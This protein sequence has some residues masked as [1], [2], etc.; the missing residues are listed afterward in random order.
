VIG[1]G[2]F[3][4][5]FGI[6]EQRMVV[7]SPARTFL[8]IGVLGGFTK[9]SSFAFETVQVLREGEWWLGTLN[10]TG[11]VLIGLAALWIAFTLGRVVQGT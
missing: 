10:V 1:C 4:L 6:G 3:G 9:C 7:G 11:Q 8:L 2:V 5:V